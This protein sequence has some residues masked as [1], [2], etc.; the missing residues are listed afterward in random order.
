M[1]LIHFSLTRQKWF[2]YVFTYVL[3]KIIQTMN[4]S[5]AGK[6]Q[7]LTTTRRQQQA[8]AYRKQLQLHESPAMQHKDRLSEHT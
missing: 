7:V 1:N 5:A 4:K 2:T 6:V 8:L 3:R